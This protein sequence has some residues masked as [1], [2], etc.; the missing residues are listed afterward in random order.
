MFWITWTLYADLYAHEVRHR[1]LSHHDDLYY[2]LL[3]ERAARAYD[4]LAE[5][6]NLV[7]EIYDDFAK[8]F[9]L[10]ELDI[11][12]L[13]RARRKYWKARKYKKL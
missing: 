4:G 12:R 5:Y 6:P 7:Q 1:E 3:L 8:E 13:L 10:H 11:A 2:E 9:Q